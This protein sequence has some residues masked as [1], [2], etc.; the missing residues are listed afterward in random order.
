M[1]FNISK[2][3]YFAS[4]IYLLAIIH[5]TEFMHL[6]FF[7]SFS[8]LNVIVIFFLF[9]SKSSVNFDAT[10]FGYRSLPMISGQ[11]RTVLQMPMKFEN[12]GLVCRRIEEPHE[13]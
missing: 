7:C 8:I 5:A 1:N 2:L 3:V 6:E 11:T 9:V 13:L 12:L 10:I 4:I